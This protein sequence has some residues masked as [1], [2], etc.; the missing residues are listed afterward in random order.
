MMQLRVWIGLTVLDEIFTHTVTLCSF[1]L[2]LRMY[3]T[4]FAQTFLL[5]KSS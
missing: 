2:S 4:N 1:S 3:K 5:P